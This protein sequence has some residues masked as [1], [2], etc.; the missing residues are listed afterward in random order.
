MAKVIL[1]CC[2]GCGQDKPHTDKFF[3]YGQRR[4][5]GTRSLIPQCRDCKNRRSKNLYAERLRTTECRISGCENGV[6][7]L[8][9]GLCSA[10]LWRQQKYGSPYELS[11]RGRR[12]GQGHITPKGYRIFTTRVNGRS[13][14]TL[15]HRMVMSEHLGRLLRKNENVHHIN[16]VR[17]DNRIENLELWVS[18][19]P[20]GQRP[21]DLLA[22]AEEI[23]DT[24]G[25]EKD[26]YENQD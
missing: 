9:R 22:W 24:Y 5:D 7:T 14:G 15:E 6:H 25:S 12:R 11:E 3:P 13:V 1:K 21:V 26:K 23:I 20:S 18:S 19:Q 10:H 16:G 8:K 4:I 2:S 17:D